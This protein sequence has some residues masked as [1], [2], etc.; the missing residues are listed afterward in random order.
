MKEQK[1][2][3]AFKI[4]F[5]TATPDIEIELGKVQEIILE[6][7]KKEFIYL[8][9]MKDGKWRLSFT[10]YT[11]PEDISKISSIK[12]IRDQENEKQT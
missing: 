3:R 10:K 1:I 4:G 6:Q 7:K 5:S 11:F 2:K 9:K 8:E 12:L